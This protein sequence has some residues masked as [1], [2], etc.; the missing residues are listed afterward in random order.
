[1]IYEYKKLGIRIIANSK[2][3]AIE[4]I[5]KAPKYEIT[6]MSFDRDKLESKIDN[7]TPNII[8]WWCLCWYLSKVENKNGLLNHEKG[9]LCGLLKKLNELSF[10]GKKSKEVKKEIIKELWINGYEYDK[11]QDAVEAEF[12]S[13]F[14]DEEIK[15][16]KGLYTEIAKEFGKEIPEL[17][18][19]IVNGSKS[20]IEKYINNKF[21]QLS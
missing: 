16:N 20:S 4:N 12:Y 5:L 10:K 13:K 9:K 21:K 6:A 1:M 8:T 3:E 15:N 14:N 7:Q 19:V 2:E 18:D 17:I 11:K